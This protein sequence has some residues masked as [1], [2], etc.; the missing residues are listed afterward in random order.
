MFHLACY[1]GS[2]GAGLSNVDIAAVSDQALTISN[3]HFVLTEPGR[4]LNAYAQG[5]DITNARV[6]TPK[7]RLISLPSL[8]PVNPGTL[9]GDLPPLVSFG[10]FPIGLDPID[11]IAVETT[12]AGA[13]A[14]THTVGLWLGFGARP[15][16]SGPAYTIRATSTITGVSGSWSAGNIVLDQ[17]LPAGR[18]SVIGLRAI[19]ANC[20]FARLIFPDMKYRPGTVASATAAQDDFSYVRFGK[21]GELGQFDSIAQPQL[22]IFVNGTCTAQTIFMDVIKVR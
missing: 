3:N 6:N 21:S 12:N 13:G 5:T 9:P 1:N 18:Y 16:P 19:A 17:V 20:V 2:V 11:E 15:I 22:E 8:T 14:E 7:L 4:L 10:D